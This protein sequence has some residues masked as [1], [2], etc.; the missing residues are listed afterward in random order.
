MKTRANSWKLRTESRQTES[1]QTV[2]GQKIWTETGQQTDTGQDFPE[3][4]DKNETRT[5]LS[6]DVWAKLSSYMRLN[7][8]KSS[9]SERWFRHRYPWSWSLR[10]PRNSWTIV[11]LSKMASDPFIPIK[12]DPSLKDLG[13]ETVI[14]ANLISSSLCPKCPLVI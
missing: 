3:S 6:A 5:V 4:P 12:R 8:S 1:G 13:Y 11:H 2:T 10:I 9:F 14:Y 7:W